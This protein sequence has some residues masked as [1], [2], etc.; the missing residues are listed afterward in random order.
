MEAEGGG[1]EEEKG[2]EAEMGCHVDVSKAELDSV[3][4]GRRGRRQDDRE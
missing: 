4:L 2:T 3:L 1:E